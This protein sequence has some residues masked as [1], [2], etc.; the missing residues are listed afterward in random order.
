MPGPSYHDIDTVISMLED[1][2][3]H[4]LCYVE[5]KSCTTQKVTREILCNNVRCLYASHMIETALNYGINTDMTLFNP[6]NYI[7]D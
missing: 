7:N 1:N 5:T 6:N 4:R 2:A 3:P